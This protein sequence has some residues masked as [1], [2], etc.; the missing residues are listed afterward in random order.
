M[1]VVIGCNII[2]LI[3][4]LVAL[5]KPNQTLITLGD[6]IVSFLERPDFTTRGMCTLT[7]DDV[8]SAYWPDDAEPRQWRYNRYSRW[9]G[10]GQRRWEACC[11]SSLL[12]LGALGTLLWVAINTTTTNPDLATWYDLGFGT[13]TK[14]SLVQWPPSHIG[15]TADLLRNVLLANLPQ[16]LLSCLYLTWNRVL[17]C[18]AFVNEWRSFFSNRQ[19]L[20]V[21]KP[22]GMQ[23]R[24]RF[25]T[26]PWSYIIPMLLASTAVHF[27][28]SQAFF[29]V[30]IDVFDFD[31]VL[32]PGDSI[33]SV[34][35]SVFAFIILLGLI[36]ILVLVGVG[37]GYLRYTGGM[38][39]VGVSS[40]GISAACHPGPGEDGT[41]VA[42]KGVRWGVICTEAGVGHLGFTSGWVGEPVPGR[43]YA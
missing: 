3:C 9:Q 32:S 4:I 5:M 17:T 16:L 37:M 31:A 8:K 18:M 41:E 22:Q 43:L 19:A 21:T 25:L 15:R 30:A 11:V 23:R 7:L 6:A 2:K 12:V 14:A 10:V 35:F 13:V 33:I 34:G 40:P 20:R 27:L 29:L 42:E 36:T 39:L 1:L 38:P 26:L 28:M 24:T